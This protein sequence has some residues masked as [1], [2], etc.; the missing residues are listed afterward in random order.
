MQTSKFIKALLKLPLDLGGHYRSGKAIP[1]DVLE[2][3]RHSIEAVYFSRETENNLLAAMKTRTAIDWVDIRLQ[4]ECR[5]CGGKPTLETNGLLI[6]GKT[7]CPFPEGLGPTIVELNVP[8]GKMVVA[9]DLRHLFPVMGDYNI[10]RADGMRKTTLAYAKAGMAHAYVGNSCPGFYRCSEEKFVIGVGTPNP[11][12]P[13]FKR[14][15]EVAR[16]GTDLWWYSVCDYDEYIR[17]GGELSESVVK[18][19]PGVYQ[20]KHVYEDC[21]HSSR[22]P[23]AYTYIE[24]VREPDPIKNYRADYDSLNPTAGQI[25]AKKMADW[26]SLFGDIIGAVNHLMCVIGN[27]ARY[28]PNGFWSASTDLRNDL[29]SVEIPVFDEQIRWYPLSDYSV[30][31]DIAGM[32]KRVRRSDYDG[33]LVND[34]FVDLAINICACI[35]KHGVI[36]IRRGRPGNAE[37]MEAEDQ[38]AESTRKNAAI[39]LDGIRKRFPD[40]VKAFFGRNPHMGA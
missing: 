36:P 15:R 27:G 24:K 13:D 40:H 4:C 17:R 31:A 22:G 38:E 5:E 29:P 32:G 21:D 8:S 35:I 7:Q 25:I 33:G 19:S 16:I 39:F 23:Q 2:I 10:N 14:S 9:N 28:H 26:P 20:F 1:E 11:K 30:V 12:W 3:T 34:S 6:R 18:C 37:E